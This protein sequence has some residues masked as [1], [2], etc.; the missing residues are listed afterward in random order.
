M[1]EFI[2]LTEVREN[3]VFYKAGEWEKFVPFGKDK[4]HRAGNIAFQVA[5]LEQERMIEKLKGIN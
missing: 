4:A 2:A 3:G 5:A 1:K